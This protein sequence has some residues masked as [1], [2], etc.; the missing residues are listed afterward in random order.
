MRSALLAVPA[1]LAAALPASAQTGASGP[2]TPAGQEALAILREAIEVPTVAGRGQ[3]PVL[4]QKLK[5][6][7]VAAGFRA[8]DVAFTPLGE[9][10]YLTARYPGRDRKAKPYVVIAHMDVVEARPADWERD[11][12]KAVVEN[13]FVY[14]RGA[15]DNKGDLAMVMAAIAKLKREGWVPSR[16][17][18]IGFSGDEETQMATTKAMADALADAALVLNADA[19]GG[20]LSADGTPFVYQVQAGEKTYAD[21]TLKISDP[22]GHSSRP[23]KTNPIAA[24]GTALARIWAYKFPPQLSPL[25]KAYLEGSAPQAPADIAPAMRAYAA[26]PKDEAAIAALSARPEYIGVIRTTCVPT[27]VNGGHAPNALPQSVEANVNCRIF[28]GTSRA[29]VQQTLGEIIAD[30]A[31][32]IAFKDNGTLE[33]IESP[34]DPRIMAAVDKAVHERA[35][36]IAIVPGMS[37]GATDSM[38]FR[39]KGITAL[40]VSASFIRPEDEFAH[41][42][43]ERLPLAT[44]D[45]GVKQWETVLRTI[46]R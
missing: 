2:A 31:I 27:M 4:A 10:G 16:D 40:A 29:G 8:E 25:T 14:G 24:M 37:A 26:N 36:G 44:L 35:P 23:G 12:F 34:L 1:L 30:P 9:T 5:A 22:G 13:G 38:H 28:P 17:I 42:L 11:P 33:S 19:G 32:G 46:A 20:E 7:L 18:V 6:R 43:N 41:G 15:I 3:V 45:P 39:A 21:Y